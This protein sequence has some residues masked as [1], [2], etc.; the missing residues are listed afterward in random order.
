MLAADNA[1]AVCTAT[2][3]LNRSNY[4]GH[5]DQ[6][7]LSAGPAVKRGRVLRVS[8]YRI[9]VRERPRQRGQRML[10]KHCH[11]SSSPSLWRNCVGTLENLPSILTFN[12]KQCQNRNQ[13]PPQHKTHLHISRAV[14]VAGA[15]KYLSWPFE[16][17]EPASASACCHSRRNAQQ[18]FGSRP[19]RSQL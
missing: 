9:S 15:N 5:H 4:R 6:Y 7:I 10:R 14:R 8:P 12:L 18:A 3:D 1:V 2:A 11:R 13:Q 17:Q 19:V 16:G